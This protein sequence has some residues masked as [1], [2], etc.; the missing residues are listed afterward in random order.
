[1]SRAAH[2]AKASRIL[3]HQPR[4]N[5]EL[6]P[7]WSSAK[8]RA[9][10]SRASSWFPSSEQSPKPSLSQESRWAEP[11]VA[12]WA[13]SSQAES[14]WPNPELRLAKYGAELDL[15]P[16][17]AGLNPRPDRGGAPP[18]PWGFS[19]IA[20]KRRRV[21]PPGFGVPN[22]A[23]LAQLLVKKNW[24]GQVRSRSYDVISWITSGNF[25]S[26][27]VFYRTLTW[28]HWCKW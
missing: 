19:Q 13:E 5:P 20:K 2:R 7:S 25:T 26:K 1:M 8:F 14:R 6:S 23:N 10:P 17:R 18:P 16:S 21:A 12:S 28:R 11:R 22:G 24:P 4:V 15:E 9:E 27:S 3:N